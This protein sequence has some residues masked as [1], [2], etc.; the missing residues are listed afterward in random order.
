MTKTGKIIL[1]AIIALAI[2][3]GV[4]FF[5]RDLDNQAQVVEESLPVYQFENEI[6]GQKEDLLNFTILP[7]AKIA[8]ENINFNGT[9]KGAWFF[10]GNILINIL[11]QDKNPVLNSYA[12]A[13]TDWMTVE[14]VDFAGNIDL[15]NLG[16][17][18]FYLEIR[19]DNPAGPDEGVNKFIQIPIVIE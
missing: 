13:T 2:I 11:D 12:T 5:G 9:I 16:S 7:G 17:G 1:L 19:N 4:F 8:K 14:P 18:N 15:T 10:E 3:G 6:L